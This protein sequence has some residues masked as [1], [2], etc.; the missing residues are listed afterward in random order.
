MDKAHA[1]VGLYTR[2]S[3]DRDGQQTAT[4]RQREDCHGFAQRKGWEV[5]EEFEDVDISAFSTKVRR[6]EFERMLVSLRTGDIDRL[7]VWKLDRLTR[8]Q[9][10]LARV[11]EACEPRKA[12]VASVTEPIDTRE[13]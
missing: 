6:P 2:I 10:D 8:Q 12:F 3:E 13:T 9:R 4:A 7:V 1:R 5:A 11:V